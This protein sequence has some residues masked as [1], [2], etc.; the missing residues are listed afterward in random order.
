MK[1]LILISV[2]LILVIC[3]VLLS[4]NEQCMILGEQLAFSLQVGHCDL[5]TATNVPVPSIA[6][7]FWIIMN[8]LFAY[9]YPK[10]NV[11]NGYKVATFVLGFPGTLFVY[12]IAQVARST[13]KQKG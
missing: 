10:Q 2:V 7:I 1:Q 3:S 12:L 4:L 8:V 13:Q 6:L 9:L 5:S 11:A